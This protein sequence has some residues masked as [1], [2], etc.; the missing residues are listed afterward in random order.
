MSMDDVIMTITIT[1]WCCGLFF[2]LFFLLKFKLEILHKYYVDKSVSLEH[3]VSWWHHG[4]VIG[5]S[6]SLYLH[7]DITWMW[8]FNCFGASQIRKLGAQKFLHPN[9]YQDTMVHFKVITYF[10]R[11]NFRERNFREVKNSRNFLDKLSR[12]EG[13]KYFRE[14]NFREWRNFSI[15][16]DILWGKRGLFS[17]KS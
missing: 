8:W 14:I 17:R 6:S 12:I 2:E 16:L 3:I 11:R 1:T 9:S 4:G 13:F 7:Y 10:N 5:L 15:I